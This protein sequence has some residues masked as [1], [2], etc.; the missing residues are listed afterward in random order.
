MAENKTDNVTIKD[1]EIYAANI[2]LFYSNLFS[3]GINALKKYWYILL[4]GFVL[5]SGFAWYKYRNAK[6]YYEGKATLTF[7]IF[8]KKVFGEML[9]KLRNLSRSGSYKTL[10]EKLDINEADAKKIIDIEGLNI[11]GSPLSDDITESKQPFYIRVKLRDRQIADTLLVR[12]ESYLNSNPQVKSQMTNN[13]I[14][15]KEKLA[16]INDQIRKL[17]TLKADYK[18]YLAQQSVNS[19]AVINT[20]NPVDLFTASEKLFTTKTDLEWG[21]INHKVVRILDPF[22]INDFPV[23]PSLS[24]LLIKYAGLGLLI[25]IILS[26]LLY[27]FKKI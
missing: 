27:T 17:D 3:F 20:F 24:G 4:L 5:G 16:F 12:I 7:T 15:M 10:S 8:N 21:I 18:F 13:L 9:D 26:L 1:I 6:P 2:K 22:I 23:L 11:A 14:K 19:G 25:T